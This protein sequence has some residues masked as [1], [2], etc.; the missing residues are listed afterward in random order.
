[1]SHC[2]ASLYHQALRPQSQPGLSLNAHQ[3]QHVH[4]LWD[5]IHIGSQA[6]TESELVLQRSPLLQAPQA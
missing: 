1:M 6:S 5:Q 3:Q 4:K 2:H